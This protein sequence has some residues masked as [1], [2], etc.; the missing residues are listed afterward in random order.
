MKRGAGLETCPLP[1][2]ASSFQRP[3]GDQQRC[4][5]W[6]PDGGSPADVRGWHSDLAGSDSLSAG[7]SWTVRSRVGPEEEVLGR[8]FG[9]RDGLGSAV[10][11]IQ[12]PGLLSSQRPGALLAAFQARSILTVVYTA[13]PGGTWFPPAQCS[14]PHSPSETPERPRRPVLSHQARAV[15]RASGAAAKPQE[16]PLAQPSVPGSASADSPAHGLLAAV[17]SSRLV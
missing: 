9:G 1:G 16:C 11:G 2:L 17:L 5:P 14:P 4:G 13:P 15:T 7:P 3:P 8:S 6:G 10:G 12:L